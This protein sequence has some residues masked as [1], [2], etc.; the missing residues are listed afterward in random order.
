MIHQS[1]TPY[2]V[3]RMNVGTIME[4][5]AG[6]AQVGESMWTLIK[7]EIIPDEE[8]R[9]EMRRQAFAMEFAAGRVNSPEV[10]EY[11]KLRRFIETAPVGVCLSVGLTL[12]A[13]GRV[14]AYP[15][16]SLIAVA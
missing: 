8:A 15:Q 6:L 2:G 4:I 3:A 10:S 9:K 16:P 1:L 11:R 7:E 5:A 13:D 12:D 14:T